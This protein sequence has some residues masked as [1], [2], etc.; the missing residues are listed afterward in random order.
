MMTAAM[1]AQPMQVTSRQRGVMTT[2]MRRHACMHQ[3]PSAAACKLQASDS[4]LISIARHAS[5]WLAFEHKD[6]DEAR[7]PRA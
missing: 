5:S 7:S 1:G 3:P 4:D 6:M 2:A